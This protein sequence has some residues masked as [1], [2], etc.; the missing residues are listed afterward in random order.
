MF[1]RREL[2]LAALCFLVFPALATADITTTKITLKSGDTEFTAELAMPEGP[3]PFPAVV[4]IQEWWGLNDWIIGNAKHFAEHGYV[5]I[6]PDLYHGHV[7]DNPSVAGQL[8]K[9]MPQ[10]RAMRDLKTCVD[11]LA[12]NPKVN[13]E[14]IGC[15]GWCLGG[16]LSLSLA[17]EDPRVQACAICYGKLVLSADKVKDMKAAILGIFGEKDTGIPSRACGN[18]N[19]RPRRLAK[20]SR[21]PST[22]Q[23]RLH[24]AGEGRTNPTPSITKS[25]PRT[26]GNRSTRSSP[27]WAAKPEHRR[28]D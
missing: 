10:D 28:N 23:A 15:V 13:K 9:G 25:R 17:L 18:S 24:A 11:E 16:G 27:I 3:G 8:M 1:H 2:L 22:R 21:D 4:V 6:A 7:T 26:P 20:R 14:K 5:A 19:R 12:K